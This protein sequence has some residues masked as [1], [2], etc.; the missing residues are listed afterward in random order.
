MREKTQFIWKKSKKATDPDACLVQKTVNITWPMN[1]R[2]AAAVRHQCLSQ[3]TLLVT[4]HALDAIPSFVC[5]AE[6]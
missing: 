6:S 5:H 4:L 2:A 1:S 3:V